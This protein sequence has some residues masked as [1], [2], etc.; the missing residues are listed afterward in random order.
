[1]KNVFFSTTQ[2]VSLIFSLVEKQEK[3]SLVLIS[4]SYWLIIERR[5]HFPAKVEKNRVVLCDFIY[6][7]QQ[8]KLFAPNTGSKEF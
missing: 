8:I 2:V 3:G 6:F 1:M 5:K 7:V 4:L